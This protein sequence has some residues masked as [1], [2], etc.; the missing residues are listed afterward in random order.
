MECF[1]LKQFHNFHNSGYSNTLQW[2]RETNNIGLTE[3]RFKQR[4]NNHTASFRNSAKRKATELSNYIWLLKDKTIKYNISWKIIAQSKAYNISSNRCALCTT[5]K[6][7]IIFQPD[8]ASLNGRRELVT[9]C[10]HFSKHTLANYK[11]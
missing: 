2:R 7:Y 9:T 5:E 4:Y 8:K 3:C 10:R 1:A 11:S 6:Y